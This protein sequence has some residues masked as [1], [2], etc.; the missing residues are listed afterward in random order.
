MLS[1]DENEMLCRVGPGTVMGDMMRQY[2]LPF[3]HDFE[4]KPD[5]PPVRVRLL[6]EDL[7]AFRATDGSFGLVDSRCP[8]RRGG[9]F[10]GRNEE[11]GLR[12]VYH[13]WK[14]DAGG[15]CLDM[16]NEPERSN[17][18]SRVTIKAYRCEEY[19]GM[20]WAYMGPKQA[21]PPGPPQLEWAL[22][23]ESH[24]WLA[25]SYVLQNN[26]LQGLEGDI[27]SS[28]VAFLHNR[29]FAD[30]SSLGRRDR[31]PVYEVVD[32]EW[33]LT[34]SARRQAGPGQIYH[35]V[36][37][38]V[39]PFHSFFAGPGHMWVP[40]DDEHTLV[41]G[42]RCDPVNELVERRTVVDDPSV[43]AG[44]LL[45]EQ[46][47][48]FFANWWPAA[49][50]Q[51]DFLIDR[52]AQRTRSFT[53]LG[54]IRND[55]SAMTVSMGSILDRSTEHL[56]TADVMII[57]TRQ[58]LLDAAVALREH[59]TPP[60]AAEHPEVCKVRGTNAILPEGADWQSELN[61]W[62]L[63]R[64]NQLSPAQAAFAVVSGRPD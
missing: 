53:G 30:T 32:T 38:M 20:I 7:V 34:G 5:D 44:T 19:G 57:R 29:N 62:C 55:D 28:H 37:Q 16:P 56:G 50:E 4:L 45:P 27:D 58:R 40:I 26:W 12:C 41:H 1:Q 54:S 47:G 52:E 46:Q 60:P 48:K 42:V 63:A 61:A 18:K 39:F 6:G 25:Y 2:W 11:N 49:G 8:H 43:G 9:M 15:A 3:L 24:R 23:P 59:G 31:A 10:Y 21:Q 35:R 13:G 64:T 22:L 17:F 33:G 51:N 36:Y 14:F